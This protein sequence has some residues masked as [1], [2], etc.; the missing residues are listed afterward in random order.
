M[1]LSY[2]HTIPIFSNP[3]FSFRAGGF[4]GAEMTGTFNDSYQNAMLNIDFYASL[5]ASSGISY[6]F[7]TPEKDLK[8][9]FIKLHMPHKKFVAHYRLD[10]PLIL[11]NGRP[12]FPY[13]AQSVIDFFDR[14][15]FLGGFQFKSDLG[16]KCFLNN[17]NAFG[18]SYLW[19]MRTTGAKDLYL[20]ET[21]SHDIMMSFYFKLD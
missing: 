15:Y 12:N 4:L 8:I 3:N 19:G 18:I 17:G 7:E 20:L 1:H 16:I 13:L 14:H 5:F 2:L 11:F 21:A 10:L 9:F 6:K